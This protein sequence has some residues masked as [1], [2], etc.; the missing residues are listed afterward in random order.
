MIKVDSSLFGSGVI[1]IKGTRLDLMLDLTA[2]LH[3]MLKK[4]MLRESDIDEVVSLAKK[5]EEEVHREAVEHLSEH[6]DILENI[7]KTIKNSK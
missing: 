7:L 1:E 2:L 4:D 6:I 5:P 3:E